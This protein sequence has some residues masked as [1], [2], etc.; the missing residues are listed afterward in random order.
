MNMVECDTLEIGSVVAVMWIDS[1][2]EGNGWREIDEGLME[3]MKEGPSYIMSYGQVMMVLENSVVLASNIT[4]G[5]KV[6]R[7]Q[8]MGTICIPLGAIKEVVVMRLPS[9]ENPQSGPRPGEFRNSNVLDLPDRTVSTI[10]NQ[11]G[12][13]ESSENQKEPEP[14]Q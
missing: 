5:N 1:W 11:F 9:K 2:G 4:P 12:T 10:S 6:V 14:P 8:L 3:H 7:P 13:P